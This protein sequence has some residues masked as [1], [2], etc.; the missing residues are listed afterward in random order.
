[1]GLMN[2]VLESTSGGKRAPRRPNDDQT[3]AAGTPHGSQILQGILAAIEQLE[4]GF[5]APAA[6]FEL[7]QRRLG[8]T[9]G[10][11]LV[12]DS[13]D[14][15]FKPWAHVGIDP[16]TRYRLTLTHNQIRTLV[17]GFAAN[18]GAHNR[19]SLV[20]Y[21][22][23]RES[24]RLEYAYLSR[25]HYRSRLAGLLVLL[26]TGIATMEPG[27][28]EML[29]TAISE[30]IGRLLVRSRE[31]VL[32]RMYTPLRLDPTDFRRSIRYLADDL[33]PSER[34]LVLIRADAGSTTR[35]ILERARLYDS[36]RAG[37]DVRTVIS[38]FLGGAGE[39]CITERGGVCCAARMPYGETGELLIEA[40]NRRLG[41]MFP[42]LPRGYRIPCTTLCYP[43]THS[44]IDEIFRE[45]F[46]T[47]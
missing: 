25:L 16:T 34:T 18:V 8:V 4:A 32:D 24:S 29:L 45:L 40:L 2:R 12:R 37:L 27:S 46:G 23:F 6:V 42:E 38:S 22:S 39:V 43:A 17:P 35:T 20:P 33:D 21:L 26:D 30:P 13:S 19:D 15:T 1:M 5:S 47:S 36:Q 41:G 9:R 28:R 10:A 14:N 31:W 11:F 44:S 7:V 3:V